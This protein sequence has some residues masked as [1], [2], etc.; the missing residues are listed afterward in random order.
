MVQPTVAPAFMA[1]PLAADTGFVPRFLMCEPSSTIGTRLHAKAKDNAPALTNFERRLGEIFGTPLPIDP[2][3]GGLDLRCL[4]L[5][6]DARELLVHYHDSVERSQSYGGDMANLTGT[7]SK[8]AEQAARIAGVLTLWRDLEAIEVKPADMADAIDLAR[9]YLLE[10]SRLANVANVSAEIDRAD[11]LRRW[12]IEQWPEPEVLV[13]DVQ[14]RGPNALRES[15]QA[16]AALLQLEAHGW[17]I[18]LD[19]GTVVR[20][21]A[22]KEAW[23]VVPTGGAPG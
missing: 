17:L 1:D 10:A 5:R 7:A 19:P 4:P 8:S 18:R 20:G 22:R 16:R 6:A 15:P 9:Y 21:R 11:Q 14:N 3:T 13:R 2:E 12:L 23:R